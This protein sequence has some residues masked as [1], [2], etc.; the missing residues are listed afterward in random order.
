[1]IG[2]KG[3]GTPPAKKGD[4]MGLSISGVDSTRN[5]IAFFSYRRDGDDK[6]F[7]LS[8]WASVKNGSYKK[9]TDYYTGKKQSRSAIEEEK[10]TNARNKIEYQSTRSAAAAL[11]ASIAKLQD[12]TLY[13]STDTEKD[14]E[15][16]KKDLKDFTEK[17]NAVIKAGGDSSDSTVIR[18]TYYMTQQSYVTENLLN[19]TG[20]TINSDNTLSFDEKELDVGKVRSLFGTRYGYGV[21]LENRSENIINRMSNMIGD[22]NNGYTSSGLYKVSDLDTNIMLNTTI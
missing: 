5:Y 14:T 8:D 15:Q 16:L 13:S 2:T 19:S 11:S 12:K 3:A 10:Q 18:N 4:T 1:M 6:Q 21:A 20:I 7:S 17:Y 22:I 9:L